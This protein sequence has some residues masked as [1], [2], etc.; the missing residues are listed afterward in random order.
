MI[1][2]ERVSERMEEEIVAVAQIILSQHCSVVQFVDMLVPQ[3][4]EKI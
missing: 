4:M 1:S 2:Q 3:I